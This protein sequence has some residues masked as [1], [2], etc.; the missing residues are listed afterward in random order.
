MAK[1]KLRTLTEKLRTK[2]KEHHSKM[3]ASDFD[4]DALAYFN[5]VKSAAKARKA[6]KGKVAKIRELDIPKDSEIYRIIE[7]GAKLKKMTVAQFVKKYRS[8]IEALMKD[9]DFIQTRETE[10]LI[11]DIAHMKPG[12]RVMV[13]DGDGYRIMPKKKDILN[14]T[15][16]TQHVMGNSDIFLIVYRVHF[17]LTGDLS[18]YLPA[19]EEY[20]DL[21]EESDI[22]NL[23][24]G[25]YPEITYLKSGKKDAV[26]AKKEIEPNSKER[27]KKGSKGKSKLGSKRKSISKTTKKK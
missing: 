18:H 13:N 6:K 24:D 14:I 7:K 12:K 3:K 8:E 16:F 10:Y 15:L 5:L 21:Y 20:E 26:E 11:H 27:K 4:G 22:M 1:R 9:G 19:T 23:L 2:I 25:Y 17:K